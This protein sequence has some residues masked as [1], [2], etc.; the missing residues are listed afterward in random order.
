M[1][2]ENELVVFADSRLKDDLVKEMQSSNVKINRTSYSMGMPLRVT[3]E[4]NSRSFFEIP[5]RMWKANRDSM[6]V[7][8]R[9]R[10]GRTLELNDTTIPEIEK[11][12][13][14]LH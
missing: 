7:T 1:E 5:L 10:Q 2:A 3:S 6:R 9:M 8:F 11:L 14:E 13:S 12:I 4:E